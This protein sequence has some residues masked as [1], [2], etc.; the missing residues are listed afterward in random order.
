MGKYEGKG[1]KAD[2]DNHSQQMNPNSD[3]Y[4]DSEED[5]D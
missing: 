4:Q 1:D 2:L 3:K 5:E